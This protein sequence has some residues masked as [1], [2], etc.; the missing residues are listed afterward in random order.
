MLRSDSARVKTKTYKVNRRIWN[1]ITKNGIL[2]IVNLGVTRRVH[3]K[4]IFSG[5]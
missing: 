3:V 2:V 1:N 4:D 5:R